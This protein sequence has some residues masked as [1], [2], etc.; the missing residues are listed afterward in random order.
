MLL[1]AA[2][3]EQLATPQ[4]VGPTFSI[5]S[6]RRV[7]NQVVG[8]GLDDTR[9]RKSRFKN[10]TAKSVTIPVGG[11]TIT[12]ADASMF[13]IF[14]DIPL[15]RGLKSG[16]A[17]NISLGFDPPANTTPGLKTAIL[18]VQTTAGTSKSVR[19]RGIA[20]AGL[21]GTNQPSLTRI[22]RAYEIPTF[23][24]EAENATVY[25][26]PPGTPTE[27][28][29]LQKMVKAGTGPVSIEVL[30]SFTAQENPPYTLGRYTPG[31]PGARTELFHTLT[32][33]FQTVQVAP[34]GTTSFD[35]GSSQF[36]LYFVSDVQVQDRVGYTEDSLNTWD[37]TNNRK[38][39]FFPF[40]T[41]DKQIVPN[42]FIMT[43]TEWDAP[44]GYDFTNIV[45]ILSNVK[46]APPG[47]S[48]GASLSVQNLNALPGSSNVIF[49]R[50]QVQNSSIGDIQH[51]TG[52]LRLKNT[53]TSNLVVNAP[54]VSSAWQLV[55]PPAFPLTISP[56]A[57]K[58]L[59]LKFIATT[60]PTKPYNQT[61]GTANPNGG[62]LYTGAIT[63][64][65]NDGANPTQSINLA[66]W[67]QSHSENNSEPSLQT[68]V[69]LMAGWQT[70]IAPTAPMPELTQ[71][72][73]IP[74]SPTFYGEETV[75]GY[76]T[77]ADSSKAVTVQQLNSF[78]SQGFKV[79][80]TWF[81]KGS[82]TQNKIF[83]I[84]SDTGQMLFPYLDGTTTPASGSFSPS[85]T[86][87]F[88]VDT[89]YSDDAKNPIK[90]AGGH[91]FRFYP[92]RDSQGNLVANT[93][94]MTMDYSNLGGENF[95]FQ[96]NVY[97]VTNI[98]PAP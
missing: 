92:L 44:V 55:N 35:P 21:G 11:I 60:L 25:P 73:N 24:G 86:F 57:I 49:N 4:A 59:T 13:H 33:D 96:D 3:A 89:E 78:H 5:N 91:H 28:V 2:S 65:S 34:Q 7:F 62:G 32:T 88:R 50:I 48:G 39:R 23:V 16:K 54:T 37:S 72:L 12:G 31:N 80:L 42:T 22:L 6:I 58:D 71:S 63:F 90:T 97:I 66:G 26:N 83:T 77:R 27:E 51:D 40:K 76:F 47:S 56:G 79:P 20:T 67:W 87:G 94:L 81:A 1:S 10:V 95:D 84:G 8:A 75:A 18:T 36:G 38:F 43:S 64:T 74:S 19:L 9:S 85:G 93:Y 14:N 46:A 52:T 17:I 45:A 70:N 69:N 53:G 15:P 68:L 61:N 30:A 29:D 82:S 98:T 41:R